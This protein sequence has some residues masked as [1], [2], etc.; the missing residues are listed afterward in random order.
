MGEAY[1]ISE[2]TLSRQ[3]CCATGATVRCVAC[4]SEFR[5]A[6]SNYQLN[7]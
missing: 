7:K 1:G 6:L 5:K 2:V 3:A 4:V